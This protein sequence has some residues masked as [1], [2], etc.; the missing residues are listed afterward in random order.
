MGTAHRKCETGGRASLLLVVFVI[1]FLLVLAALFAREWT[2]PGDQGAGYMTKAK[3]VI[4][5]IQ[6]HK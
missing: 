4:T 6:V 2:M 5:H 3:I 1:L